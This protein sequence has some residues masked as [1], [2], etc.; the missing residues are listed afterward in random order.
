MATST[1]PGQLSKQKF[2]FT[3]IYPSETLV[4]GSGYPCQDTP[5]VTP[6]Q[7]SVNH[8]C[9]EPNRINWIMSKI[10]FNGPEDEERNSIR[11][12]H[13]NG[14]DRNM[15][16][17]RNVTDTEEWA[18]PL[19]NALSEHP[20]DRG[21]GYWWYRPWGQK[22][23]PTEQPSLSISLMLTVM[24]KRS[25]KG[26]IIHIVRHIQNLFT[27]NCIKQKILRLYRLQHWKVQIFILFFLIKPKY[28]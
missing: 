9:R 23:P 6:R 24:V 2:W 17:C 20:M 15:Y 4:R 13:N 28:P 16:K 12:Y 27:N 19:I 3:K 11:R 26:S 10:S 18:T 7:S 14:D 1:S 25:R 22:S 8:Y 5:L 21:V